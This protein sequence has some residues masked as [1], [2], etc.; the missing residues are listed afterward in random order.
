MSDR[1]APV[2]FDYM[3][4]GM[5]YA[6]SAGII[7]GSSVTHRLGLAAGTLLCSVVLIFG[8]G[9]EIRQRYGQDSDSG[10]DQ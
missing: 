4:V 8:L 1:K 9:Y 7:I 6:G 3:G 5:C 10:S 2:G